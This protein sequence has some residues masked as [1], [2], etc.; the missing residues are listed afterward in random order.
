MD[1]NEL[2]S[3]EHKNMSLASPHSINQ[4]HLLTSSKRFILSDSHKS[5]SV[6]HRCAAGSCGWSNPSNSRN[7]FVSILWSR[8]LP[9]KSSNNDTKQLNVGHCWWAPRLASIDLPLAFL[10]RKKNIFNLFRVF[11]SLSFWLMVVVVAANNKK[12]SAHNTNNQNWILI[13]FRICRLLISAFAGSYF[14]SVSIVV[15][16]AVAVVVLSHS[17]FVVRFSLLLSRTLMQHI[18]FIFFFWIKLRFFFV[19]V[20]LIWFPLLSY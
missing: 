14:H 2:L 12:P 20:N 1:A 17:F 11:I 3:R 9:A 6:R 5:L 18:G 16:G 19:I 7:R 10:S 4:R 13:L 8:E 15:A